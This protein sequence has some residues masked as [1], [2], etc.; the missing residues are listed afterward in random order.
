MIEMF[1]ETVDSMPMKTIPD[2]FAEVPREMV[3]SL[4]A[5]EDSGFFEHPGLSPTG[6]VRALLSNLRGGEVRQGGSTITQQLVKNRF[7]T[8]ERTVRRKLRE[9]LLAILVEMRYEK[10]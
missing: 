3:Q 8:P 7:L 9:A 1:G 5:A 2:V 10:S 6:I 4:L